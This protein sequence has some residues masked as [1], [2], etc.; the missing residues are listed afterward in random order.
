MPD[1]G[2]TMADFAACILDGPWY[3]E[4]GYIGD[5]L[6]PLE[7]PCNRRYCRGESEEDFTTS[8]MV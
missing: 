7:Y 5:Y 4:E 8:P 3:G 6:Q 1:S 2:L